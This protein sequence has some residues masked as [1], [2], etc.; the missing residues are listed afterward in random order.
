MNDK[1]R[2]K[3]EVERRFYALFNASKSGYKQPEMERHRLAG[4]INAGVFLGL[5][6]NAEMQVLME[7][8]HGAVFGKTMDQ[9]RQRRS[10]FWLDEGRDYAQYESPAFERR[11]ERGPV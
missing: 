4:F 6:S 7:S 1:Q 8:V 11:Q 3:Q 9:R 5:T 2:F 10:G